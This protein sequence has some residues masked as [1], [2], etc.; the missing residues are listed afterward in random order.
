MTI[1]A[2]ELVSTVYAG[3]AAAFRVDIDVP[4]MSSFDL[5]LGILSKT[6]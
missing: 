5:T 3:G 1:K 6:A 2:P 4:T